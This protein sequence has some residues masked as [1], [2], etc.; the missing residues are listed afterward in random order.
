[1]ADFHHLK[2]SLKE[3][4]KVAVDWAGSL[5]WGVKL[6]WDYEQH[7]VNC[8]MPGYIDKA[9]KSTG[10]L[11]LWHPK[12]HPMPRLLSNTIQ[13]GTKVQQVDIKTTSPL[14][15]TELK[16]VQDIIGTLLYYT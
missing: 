12:M 14:L 3:Y 15:Y 5:F 1:M 11:C 4:C 8:S 7:H 9:L 13:Y 10:I 16:Q 6:T 2:R